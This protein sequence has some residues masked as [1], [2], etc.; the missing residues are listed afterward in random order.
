MKKNVIIIIVMMI[1]NMGCNAQ[2]NGD[3][4]I[5]K[6][7]MNVSW[8]FEK[9]RIFFEMDAP[10]DGWVTVG[11]NTQSGTTGAYLLMGNIVNGKVNVVEHYT[12]SPGDYSPI[13]ELG[14]KS[15]VEN[16]GGIEKSNHTLIKFSLPIKA[17]SKYQKELSEGSEYTMIIAYSRE[18]DFQHHSMMRTSTNVKL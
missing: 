4:E 16:I 1:I 11:F 14:A 3:K 12:K 6:N 5:S 7:K 15:Q 17:L 9:G 2:I 18:D 10:T 8:R 13:T